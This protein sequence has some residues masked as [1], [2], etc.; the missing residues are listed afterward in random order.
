MQWEQKISLLGEKKKISLER[1]SVYLR[2]YFMAHRTFSKPFSQIHTHRTVPGVTESCW[3]TVVMVMM[4]IYKYESVN[5][6]I[7]FLCLYKIHTT[8]CW[9]NK[10]SSPSCLITHCIISDV[11]TVGCWQGVTINVG[12]NYTKVPPPEK[13]KKSTARGIFFRPLDD[14]GKFYI[15]RTPAV[16]TDGS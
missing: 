2:M 16:H 6:N 14:T 15:K 4:L 8:H 11:N 3:Q 5:G 9:V 7:S 12:S 10:S 13:K 1:K